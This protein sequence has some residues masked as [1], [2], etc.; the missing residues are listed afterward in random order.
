MNSILVTTPVS[1]SGVSLS[2]STENPWCARTGADTESKKKANPNATD[3]LVLKIAPRRTIA[4]LASCITSGFAGSSKMI[5]RFGARRA[6]QGD[7]ARD[8]Q[9]PRRGGHLANANREIG[10]P[11]SGPAK[12]WLDQT[13]CIRVRKSAFR[14][15][16]EN[17]IL[18]KLASHAPEK[19]ERSSHRP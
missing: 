9:S 19:T 6:S 1:I 8:R 5:S 17:T 3:D 14:H 18:A 15:Q 11:R 2:N 16:R 10:V 12:L 13:I 4:S 7:V